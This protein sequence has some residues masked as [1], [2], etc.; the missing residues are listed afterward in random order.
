MNDVAA[1]VDASLQNVMHLLLGPFEVRQAAATM[2]YIICKAARKVFKAVT[3]YD[4]ENA[5]LL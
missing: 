2:Q 1:H 3:A 5:E 4:D